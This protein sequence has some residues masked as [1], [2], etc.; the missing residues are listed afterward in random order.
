MVVIN[1][2]S[3]ESVRI[4]EYYVSKRSIPPENIVRLTTKEADEMD[5][6]VLRVRNRAPDIGSA[7]QAGHAG[8]HSL[9]RSHEGHST[10]GARYRWR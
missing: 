5:R 7:H 3:P 6:G 1:E 4:G 10:A 2:A 9:H 8:S